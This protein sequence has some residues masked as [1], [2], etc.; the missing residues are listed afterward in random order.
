MFGWMM[1]Q[2][3]SSATGV[4]PDRIKNYYEKNKESFH[5]QAS[6]KVRQIYLAPVAD[7]PIAEQAAKI[8]QEARQPGANFVDLAEKYS[9]DPLARAGNLPDQSFTSDNKLPPEVR[10]AIFKLEPGDVSDPVT[11]RDPKTGDTRIFIF[12]CDEKISEGY[13]KL[14]DVRPVIEKTLV[15]QDD[16]QAQEKWLQ[17]LRDKAYIKYVLSDNKN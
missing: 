16:K 9:S 14:E 15:A 17:R 4:S 7:S 13:Q 3:S 10:D 2:I 5:V 12:K 11:T 1:Q 8:V 6:V